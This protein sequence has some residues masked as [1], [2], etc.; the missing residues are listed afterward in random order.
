[1]LVPATGSAAARCDD[2]RAGRREIGDQLVVRVE[3]LSPDGY[4]QL[5]RLAGGAVLEGSAAGIAS[6]G[7]EP[8]APPEAGEVAEVRVR[9]EDDVAAGAAV[10][11]VG[12]ALRDV[13]LTAE[14]QAAVTPATR[15]HVDARAVV[16]HQYLGR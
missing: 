9:N 3:D 10:A 8:A 15:L 12:P 1:V 6:A 16:E 14:V 11:A 13:L 4:A 5:D 2:A 7:L